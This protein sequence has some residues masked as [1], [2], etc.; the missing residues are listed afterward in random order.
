MDWALELQ[1]SEVQ[2][3]EVLGEHLCLRF[4][5]AL[6]RQGSNALHA[7][8]GHVKGVELRLVQAM[9]IG[10]LAL[11]TGAL[12]DSLVIVD[13]VV[14][15]ELPVGWS[16]HG[17]IQAE[18]NFRSGTTLTVSAQAVHCEAPADPHFQTSYAC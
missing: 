6:V 2:F 17:D 18:L 1:G 4:S 14:R 3:T 7:E 9:W 16:A 15:R 5:A 8:V 13:G 11:C 12:S 10:E